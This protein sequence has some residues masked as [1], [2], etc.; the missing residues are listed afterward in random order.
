MASL[1]SDP[2][3]CYEMCVLITLLA[4]TK[5]QHSR[6]LSRHRSRHSRRCYSKQLNL[7]LKSQQ[8]IFSTSKVYSAS[9]CSSFK[10]GFFYKPTQVLS[11]LPL[12]YQDVRKSFFEFRNTCYFIAVVNF[13]S[14]NCTKEL[15][16]ASD[17]GRPTFPVSR[18]SPFS[19]F[20]Y[21]QNTENR[22]LRGPASQVNFN[23]S[24]V[25]CTV[26]PTNKRNREQKDI[27][28]KKLAS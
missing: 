23:T 20:V 3:R 10:T 19:N 8:H 11:Q 28:T 26:R 27:L 25:L 4:I 15:K 14:R 21:G 18:T 5:N 2:S 12:T 7:L 24:C 13:L 1:Q 6:S 17:A 9:L 16:R 22:P